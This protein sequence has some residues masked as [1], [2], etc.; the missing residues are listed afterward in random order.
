MFLLPN[1]PVG[2]E[3]QNPLS[4]PV[5]AG[6]SASSPIFKLTMAAAQARNQG[7]FIVPAPEQAVDE[8]GMENIPTPGRIDRFHPVSRVLDEAAFGQGDVS[9]GPGLH[10]Q[11]R[12]QDRRCA[13]RPPGVL[14][15]RKAAAKFSEEMK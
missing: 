7:I 6:D 10:R 1:N 2:R 14:F 9:P 13:D 4:R 8:T 3:D 5:R 11:T 12:G 15:P